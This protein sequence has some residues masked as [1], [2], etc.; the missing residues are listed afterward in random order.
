MW[1][2]LWLAN[3]RSISWNWCRTDGRIIS[4]AEW[5]ARFGY[6]EGWL[7][8]PV[9]WKSAGVFLKREDLADGSALGMITVRAV[10]AGEG[11]LYIAGGLQLD[12][13]FLDSL[14]A[15][16]A[17]RVQL[18]R[19]VEP[20]PAPETLGSKLAA[21]LVE[22]V[23]KRPREVTRKDAKA[24]ITALPL[25]GRDGNCLR[26]CWSRTRGPSWRA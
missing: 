24:S 14:P 4:S 12:K 21:D 9:D 1:R 8:E 23:R 5:P 7:T 25:E 3:S 20:L 11:T 15:V 22:D 18:Y 10:K 17:M 2:R 6:Q 26:S 13:E 19:N 16:E